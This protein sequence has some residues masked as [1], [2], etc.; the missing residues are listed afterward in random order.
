MT[1]RG[2]LPNEASTT[3]QR[4]VFHHQRDAIKAHL[5]VAMTA[6]AL[7]RYLQETTRTSIK[8]II[9]TPLQDVTINLNDHKTT[10]QP[11]ITP[12]TPN[13]PKS[14]RPQ[15]TKT[16]RVRPE[17]EATTPPSIAAGAKTNITYI[18][19]DARSPM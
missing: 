15:D 11:Q 3:G 17:I 10:T 13:T 14:L 1:R 8:R 12:T 5:T 16:P 6:L 19:K 2:L 9:P 4:P 7:A 18:T